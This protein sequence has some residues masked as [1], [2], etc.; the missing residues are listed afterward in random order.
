MSDALR[1]VV[2]IQVLLSGVTSSKGP[3]F[4]LWQAA[5]LNSTLPFRVDTC[6]LLRLPLTRSF[7]A[8]STFEGP[9]G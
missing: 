9:C 5:R 6:L 2:D 7:G 8:C 4:D 1:L 3:S